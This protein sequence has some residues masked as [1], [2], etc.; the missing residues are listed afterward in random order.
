MQKNKRLRIF[1][2]PNGSGKSTL[3]IE[4]KKHFNPGYFINADEFEKLLNNSGLIDLD[5]FELKATTKNL[6]AYSKTKEAKTLLAKAGKEGHSINIDIKENFI[7]DKAKETH[8]YE[9]SFAA[10]FVRWLLYKKD[11]SF[12]FETVMSDGS[13]ISEVK[14]AK[15]KGYQIYLYFICTDN[16]EINIKRVTSRVEKGGHPVNEN[17]IRSRYQKALANLFP[18]IKLAKR[19]YLFDNSGKTMELIE[20]IFEGSLQ[21]KVDTPPHWFIENVLP[22]YRH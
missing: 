17:K 1:A 5:A 12:A 2:G 19:V 14:K 18:V 21:L 15:K 4:F 20:E 10:A 11:I 8:S 6:G 3:F 9:A 13:K 7:V 22:Y 16:E